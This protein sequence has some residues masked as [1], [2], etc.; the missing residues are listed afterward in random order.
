MNLCKNTFIFFQIKF[1]NYWYFAISITKLISIFKRTLL[2]LSKYNL[3]TNN[4]HKI[5]IV[6]FV[7]NTSNI[8]EKEQE[9]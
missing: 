9:I 2:Y 1:K 7:I 6:R 3:L 4:P 8:I 5:Y